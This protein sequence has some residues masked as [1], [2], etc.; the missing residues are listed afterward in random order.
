MESSTT[1]ARAPRVEVPFTPELEARTREIVASIHEALDAQGGTLPAPLDDSPKCRGCS[2]S[3]ICLPDET[4]A[5]TRV[6]EVAGADGEIRRLIPRTRRRKYPF[7]L[8]EQGA[9]VGKKR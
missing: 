2:L 4:L 8:Q 6:P 1:L 3:G 5:L 7:T 9:Y